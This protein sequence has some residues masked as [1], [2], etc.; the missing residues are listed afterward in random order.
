MFTTTNTKAIA[1]R[2]GVTT[3]NVNAIARD[4]GIE[5]HYRQDLRHWVVTDRKVAAQLLEFLVDA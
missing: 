5:L 4:L 2:A 1:K 3:A